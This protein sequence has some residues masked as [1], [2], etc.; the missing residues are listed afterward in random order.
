MKYGKRWLWVFGTIIVL[1]LVLLIPDSISR[2][3]LQGGSGAFRWNE[4]TTWYKLEN[5]FSGLRNSCDSIQQT[6]EISLNQLR[7]NI[8]GVYVYFLMGVYV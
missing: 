4:D 2:V 1:Y 7:T 5:R 6:I 3:K 8:M